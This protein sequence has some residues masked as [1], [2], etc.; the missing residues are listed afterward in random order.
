MRRLALRVLAVL[1]ALTV[2]YIPG[3]GLGS[4]TFVFPGGQSCTDPREPM[5]ACRLLE[6]GYGL[7]LVLIVVTGL[8]VQLHRPA[9][10]VA[11]LQQVGLAAG[12]LGLTA[13]LGL[14]WEGLV[15]FAYVAVVFAVIAAL[16]PLRREVFRVATDFEPRLLGLAALACIPLLIQAWQMA[17]NER[18]G[19]G[20][21]VEHPLASGWQSEGALALA[22]ALVA[23]WSAG[24]ASG[25]RISAW[26]AAALAFGF[27]HVSF[28]N[29]SIPASAGRLWG[30]LAMVW[31]L[32]FVV[33]SQL[34]ARRR[35]T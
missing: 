26:S 33:L 15:G 28:A 21:L 3:L 1:F 25:W 13:M 19:S 24:R 16:H 20:P 5:D 9:Q 32:A 22:I 8:L 7:F 14:R 35:P 6:G 30:G 18:A 4:F 2:L 12:V 29:P 17:A 31:A 27:G 23:L 34:V 10:K 11:P